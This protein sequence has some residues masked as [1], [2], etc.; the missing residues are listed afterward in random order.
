MRA[1]TGCE[2]GSS[3]GVGGAGKVL[4]GR[5]RCGDRS[6]GA[7]SGAVDLGRARESKIWILCRSTRR[8]ATPC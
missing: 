7:G 1:R 4:S 3:A 6:G 2:R 5:E 8:G